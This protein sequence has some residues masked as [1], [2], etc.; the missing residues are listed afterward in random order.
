[1]AS[2]V[3]VMDLSDNREELTATLTTGISVNHFISVLI[4][5]L[6][7]FIWKVV[8][9]EVLFTISAI[10]GVVNSIFAATITKPKPR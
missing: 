6:G 10:L 4:A 9:I 7:G 8:G 2:N 1:M 3:Y 5:L